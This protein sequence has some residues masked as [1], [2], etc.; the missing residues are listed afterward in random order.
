[1]ESTNKLTFGAL[2]FLMTFVIILSIITM[3]LCLTIKNSVQV[4][5]DVTTG[6]IP[7]NAGTD[8]NPANQGSVAIFTLFESDGVIAVKNA[9]GEV[10]RT[11]GAYPA[12]MPA[13][14]REALAAGIPV[15]SESELASLIEDFSE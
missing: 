7:A 9:G 8:E 12:F 10:V 6:D 11:V 2:F 14:D 3:S 15:Y 4:D 1:M 5:A 13:A